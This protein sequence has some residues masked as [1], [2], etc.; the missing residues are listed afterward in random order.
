MA[1]EQSQLLGKQKYLRDL[2]WL[3]QVIMLWEGKK[4][5]KDQKGFQLDN[6]IIICVL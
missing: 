1:K 4:T 6:T 2:N 3:N 5:G